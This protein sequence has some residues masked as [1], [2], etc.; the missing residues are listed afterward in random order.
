FHQTTAY[1]TSQSFIS[2]DPTDETPNE[3]DEWYWLAGNSLRV[4]KRWKG[5]GVAPAVE[6]NENPVSVNS[7]DGSTRYTFQQSWMPEE[8]RTTLIHV[9]LPPNFS[10]AIPSL[11]G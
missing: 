3:T 2:W 8:D 7:S 4:K 9:A 5:V 1:F 11:K 6:Y 10:V